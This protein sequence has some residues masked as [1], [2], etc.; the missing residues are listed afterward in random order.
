MDILTPQWWQQEQRLTYLVARLIDITCMA[1][2]RCRLSLLTDSR[3]LCQSYW[4]PTSFHISAIE[5]TSST[6][7]RR[8]LYNAVICPCHL[9]NLHAVCAG[10]AC[11]YQ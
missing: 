6:C 7:K 10:P 2:S 5:A 11:V 9:H 8:S 3:C 1:I 4:T